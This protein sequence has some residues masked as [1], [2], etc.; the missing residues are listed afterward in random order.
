M[1]QRMPLAS[2]TL[3]LLSALAPGNI[4]QASFRKV[5][6]LAKLFPQVI[7]FTK[8]AHEQ[9]CD[10]L[11]KFK[12][13]AWVKQQLQAMQE[14]RQQTQERLLERQLTAEGFWGKVEEKGIWPMLSKLFTAM[15]CLP[16][17]NADC[18]RVFSAL[19]PI[20]TRLRS[21][22]LASTLVALMR[23]KLNAAQFG[24]NV[25]SWQPSRVFW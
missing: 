4:L 3:I 15:C 6:E 25:V 9:L 19:L 1:L 8:Q 2:P 12:V 5:Q 16:H 17:A 10:E 23:C 24:M 20:K 7:D 22:L 14:E 18:E 21:C 11:R 13:D